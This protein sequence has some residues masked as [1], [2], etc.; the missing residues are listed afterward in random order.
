MNLEVMGGGELPATPAHF[1][2]VRLLPRVDALVLFQ[3]TPR[4][5]LFVA[6]DKIAFE[7]VAGVESLV[8]HQSELSRVT[9]V[10]AI[11]IALV[12]P[13]TRVTS[14]VVL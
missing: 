6:V 2:L 1:A 13:L 11:F 9:F 14:F 10:A 4:R 8:C 5:E 12:R 3:I 7:S